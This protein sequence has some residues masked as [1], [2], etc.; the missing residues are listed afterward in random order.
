MTIGEWID[1][2]SRPVPGAFRGHLN[3]EDPVSLET[4]L[5]AAEAEFHA[6]GGGAFRDRTAA[7]CLL[8]ADAYITYACLWATTEGTAG[9]LGRIA[10]RIARAWTPGE[11]V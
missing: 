10:E 3:A 6:C 11:P 4:L 2:R 8:A 7:F 1:G 9:D 5:G